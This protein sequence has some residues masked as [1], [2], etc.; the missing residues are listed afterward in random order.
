[1]RT[2]YARLIEWRAA[3]CPLFFAHQ[4]LCGPA[5]GKGTTQAHGA[6]RR[7][8]DTRQQKNMQQSSKESHQENMQES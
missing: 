4:L 5:K 3:R 8:I 6:Q 7:V 1:M 2:H